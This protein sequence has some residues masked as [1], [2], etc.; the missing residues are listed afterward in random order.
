MVWLE[1]LAPEVFKVAEYAFLGSFRKFSHSRHH[2][3]AGWAFDMMY[4][5]STD[6]P[7]L[8]LGGVVGKY[9]LQKWFHK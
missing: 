5:T 2:F 3:L 1:I 8:V 4:V 6:P 7:E 9:W